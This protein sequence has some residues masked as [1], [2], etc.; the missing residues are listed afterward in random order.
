MFYCDMGPES[1]EIRSFTKSRSVGQYVIVDSEMIHAQL[2]HRAHSIVSL[3]ANGN[4][5]WYKHRERDTLALLTEEE[6]KQ[7]TMQI[8]KSET[9]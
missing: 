5:I 8:M 2:S 7:L 6:K 4:P 9:W 1:A 3:T